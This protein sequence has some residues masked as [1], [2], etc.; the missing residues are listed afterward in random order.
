MMRGSLFLLFLLSLWIAP[1]TS[2][3]GISS[4]DVVQHVDD[5]VDETDASE[6]QDSVHAGVGGGVEVKVTIEVSKP[7]SP[8]S[9]KEEKGI[10]RDLQKDLAK[11]IKLAGVKTKVLEKPKV[12]KKV[13]DLKASAKAYKAAMKKFV[14]KK[15]DHTDYAGKEVRY[16]SDIA[17]ATASST[18]H[19]AITLKAFADLAID[20]VVENKRAFGALGKLLEALSKAKVS[21]K[22]SALKAYVAAMKKLKYDCGSSGGIEAY[23]LGHIVTAMTKQGIVY[24][25]K[26]Q[27]TVNAQS[28]GLKSKRMGGI[29]AK[30]K[31]PYSRL[32][33]EGQK[34]IKAYTGVSNP[35]QAA[36][37]VSKKI[38]KQLND[39]QLKRLKKWKGNIV[40][41]EDNIS[42]VSADEEEPGTR[43]QMERN[44][45]LYAGMQAAL[46]GNSMLKVRERARD[47]A[48]AVGA[49]DSWAE[50]VG[51]EAAANAEEVQVD[52]ETI[53]T[54]LKME[55][56]AEEFHKKTADLCISLGKQLGV[57]PDAIKMEL[58]KM[59]KEHS[60]KKKKVPSTKV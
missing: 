18:A 16:A 6:I 30:V 4:S 41:A 3:S 17:V 35:E 26:G 57:D 12:R 22:L 23:M 31:V 2:E 8:D 28:L 51:Q 60:K 33:K 47:A 45:G 9:K 44:D 19:N 49:T 37:K 38:S 11:P 34:V 58:Q 24:V 52:V 36:K 14:P 43:Q 21:P 27:S 29:L 10:V 7:R 56:T 13:V 54:K 25:S 40:Q 32:I 15:P 50:A 39:K 42:L 20:E 48:E 1:V 46:R 59:H 53:S 5:I 55:L